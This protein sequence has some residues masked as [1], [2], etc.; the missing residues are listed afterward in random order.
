MLFERTLS[1][2]ERNKQVKEEGGFNCIPFELPRF[3][4]ILPGIM[5]SRMYTITASSGVGKSKFTKKK[6]VVDPYDF[7]ME[8][9]SDLDLKVFYFALEESA[10]NFI[11]SMIVNKLYEE[12]DIY[13]DV[14]TVMSVSKGTILPEEVIDKIKEMRSYFEAFEDKVEVIEGSNNPY[15]IYKRM[16]EY[17]EDNGTLH[18]KRVKDHI[19][20]ELKDVPDHYEPNN[21]DEYVIGVVDHISLLSTERAYPTIHEA[22]Q[23]LSSDYFVSLK[24]RFGHT[25]V[26]VQQ[27]AAE[28][29]KKE[30]TNR[31]EA[32]QEKLE[33]TLDGLAE[34][35]KT[36]RDTS[37]ALGLF[38]PNR[39]GIEYHA[40]YD[41]RKLQDKYRSL[42]ILKNSD[43]LSDARLGLYFDGATNYFKE[44]P[45]Q[46]DEQFKEKIMKVQQF[47][48]EQE[49]RTI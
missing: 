18:T 43:G 41:V 20:G 45:S 13:T 33:P 27:Q 38:A 24:N 17:A 14:N 2:I 46:N 23:K 31:G 40:G 3:E 1:S 12:H 15:G 37:V 48:K 10:E 30:F 19:T 47:K 5:K 39:Y 26:N 28:S 35:K 4:G 42:S 6:F 21:P 22:I 44:L 9:D 34:N 11:N 8:Q 29:E 49:A 32:I 7:V 25:I 16:R 36:A